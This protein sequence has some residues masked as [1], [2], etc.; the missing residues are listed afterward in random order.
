MDFLWIFVDFKFGLGGFED[1]VQLAIQVLQLLQLV[2]QDS[3]G[4][5]LPC[6]SRNDQDQ[7]QH[8][9]RVFVHRL[10]QPDFFRFFFFSGIFGPKLK[11]FYYFEIFCARSNFWGNDECRFW[12]F[13]ASFWIFGE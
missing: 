7:F 4:L 12:I 13:L 6:Y 11:V 10:H 1:R 9:L 2:V 8:L 5:A 3:T